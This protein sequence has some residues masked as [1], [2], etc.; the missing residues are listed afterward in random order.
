ME[1]TMEE[2]FKASDFVT[3]EYLK[4]EFTEAGIEA[5]EAYDIKTTTADITKAVIDALNTGSF[6]F[7]GKHNEPE[8]TIKYNG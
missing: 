6:N 2:I 5:L 1:Y 8:S 7:Y 4:A 3:E